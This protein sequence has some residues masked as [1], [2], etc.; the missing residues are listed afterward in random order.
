MTEEL[1]PLISYFKSKLASERLISRELIKTTI[2]SDP[3]M[4]PALDEEKKDKLLR[5]LEASFVIV[6]DS[7][8]I[9][10]DDQTYEPW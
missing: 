1:K 5:H 6:Q 7:G 9:V 4:G 3:I 2:A 8:A 10:T